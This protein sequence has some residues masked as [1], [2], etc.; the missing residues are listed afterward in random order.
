LLPVLHRSDHSP[1]WK[2]GIPSVLWTDTAEFRNANY[3]GASDRPATLDYR[4]LRQV[5]ELLL[6]GASAR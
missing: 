6:A 1:F 5:T 2:A 3:H 4:F